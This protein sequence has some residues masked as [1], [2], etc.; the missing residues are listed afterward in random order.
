MVGRRS[1]YSQEALET[2][3]KRLSEIN[4]GGHSILSGVHPDHSGASL[5]PSP[6]V[7]ETSQSINQ[8]PY[9][10]VGSPRLLMGINQTL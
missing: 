4:E 6:R 10:E 7:T 8:T 5:I 1:N 2:I 3:D 9:G